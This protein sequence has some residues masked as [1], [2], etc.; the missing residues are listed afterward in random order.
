M[1]VISLTPTVLKDA[2]FTLDGNDYSGHV[3]NVTFTPTST[4]ITFKGLTPESVYTD[5][6]N[7]TYGVAI[8]YAQ[9]S[10]TEDSLTNLLFD[11]EGE[12]VE[13][14]YAASKSTGATK[15]TAQVKLVPGVIGGAGDSYLTSTV[16]LGISG[17]PVK[18]TIA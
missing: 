1:A 13:L 9:D 12:T 14:V 2:L 15:Y 5:V 4:T 8:T 10:E 3:N 16:T 11:K 6:T 17:R 7:A 18:G